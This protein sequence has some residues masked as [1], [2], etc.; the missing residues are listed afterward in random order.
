MLSGIIPAAF[1][2]GSF[3]GGLVYGR[4]TWSQAT[5]DQLIIASA[6]FL[7]GCSLSRPC[8]R[9]SRPPPRSPCLVRS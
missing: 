2:T 1:S 9:P 6:A 7:A 3:L 8:L 5:A 4:R